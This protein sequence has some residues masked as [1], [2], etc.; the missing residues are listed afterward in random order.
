[1]NGRESL[2][3]DIPVNRQLYLPQIFFLRN[4]LSRLLQL[5]LF[6]YEATGKTSF[7]SIA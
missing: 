4:L 6:F 2:L 7:C 1:M 3:T 5:H